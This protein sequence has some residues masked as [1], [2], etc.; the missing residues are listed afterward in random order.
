[1]LYHPPPA[2]SGAVV[3]RPAA[4][5]GPGGRS[6]PGRGHDYPARGDPGLYRPGQV[7]DLARAEPDHV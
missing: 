5:G 2:C 3:L 7:K 1:M 6:R 4:G